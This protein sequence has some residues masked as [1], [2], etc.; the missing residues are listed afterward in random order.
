MGWAAIAGI[1][2]GA[3]CGKVR[4]TDPARTATEQFLL[5]GAARKALSQLSFDALHNRSVYLESR[6]YGAPEQEFVMGE[7]R[8]N[9]LLAGVRLVSTRDEAEIVVEARSGGV[10]IDRED[11]LLG[12][13]ALV[14]SADQGS[15]GVP[16]QTPEISLIKNTEQVGVASVAFVAFWRET[17]EVVAASGPFVGVTFR[18]DWWF[19]G[20]GPRTVGDIPPTDAEPGE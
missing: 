17:G 3:G 11:F 16:F 18:D 12:V 13:P 2:A 19:L 10:G 14:L 20:V 9:M 8:A 15:L 1:A 4:V 5:S 7:L 6:Y